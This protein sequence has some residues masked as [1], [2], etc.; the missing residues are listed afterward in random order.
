MK[1]HWLIWIPRVLAIL[2]GLLIFL[3][4]LD[5]FGG[6]AGFWAKLGGFFVHNI[7]KTFA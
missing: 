7:P 3:F 6:E 4:S 2:L 1:Q 5:S